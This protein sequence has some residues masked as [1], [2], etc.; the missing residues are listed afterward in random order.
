MKSNNIKNAKTISLE[1]QQKSNREILI[2]EEAS[3]IVNIANNF[4]GTNYDILK[5]EL[6]SLKD[7]RNKSY[8]SD[9]F[10]LALANNFFSDEIYNAIKNVYIERKIGS[11]KT[12]D[13]EKSREKTTGN[14]YGNIV[15]KTNSSQNDIMN[16]IAKYNHEWMQKTSVGRFKTG[17]IA[18]NVREYI[19]S[20]L[21]NQIMEDTTPKIRLHVS[22][23]GEVTILSKYLDN[24]QTFKDLLNAERKEIVKNAKNFAN[25]FVGNL[26]VGDW[27]LN[28]GNV[29]FIESEDGNKNLARIDLG[30]ALFYS[31][32]NRAPFELMEEM[33]Y[34]GYFSEEN[35]TNLEF[36]TSLLL[37]KGNIDLDAIK[38]TLSLSF[39]NLRSAYGDDFL[40]E[41][42]INKDLKRRLMIDKETF[43]TEEL[44]SK[45]IVN[46]IEDA[47]DQVIGF[48][49]EKAEEVFPIHSHEAL[50]ECIELKANYGH[51]DYALLLKN[52]KEKCPDFDYFNPLHLVREKDH[53]LTIPIQEIFHSLTS[54]TSEKDFSSITTNETRRND[55]FSIDRVFS[56]IIEDISSPEKKSPP[57]SPYSEDRETKKIIQKSRSI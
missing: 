35:F 15:K 30:L 32:T 38:K 3:H 36:L 44:I 27:D 34:K 21:I 19:A 50:D 51:I 46:N 54:S 8:K 4:N 56:E 7:K 22:E 37:E 1:E 23:E 42:T 5:E 52:L 10:K 40:Q 33:Q 9:A 57:S 11:I 6:S 43:L 20:N 12:R 24:F 41:Q 13:L 47:L 53:N 17:E 25:F 28:S 29:G 45:K 49:I 48:V 39:R 16:N 2:L 26:L 55:S 18:G 31:P 14:S